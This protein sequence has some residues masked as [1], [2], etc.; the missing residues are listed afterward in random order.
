MSDSFRQA[1]GRKVISRATA[2]ELGEVNHLLLDARR[3]QIGAV[4]IGKGKKAQLVEWAQVT[5]FGPDAVMV[6][7]EGALRAPAD[8]RERDAAEGKLDL[9][10]KRALT[11][12]GTELGTID[13][14]TFDADTGTVEMLRIS[15]KEVPGGSVLGN[16]TYAVIIDATQV[17]AP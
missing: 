4:I 11:E 5:G 13:D 12:T 2:E 15:D 1:A 10:G 3:Q 7:D 14:V 9:V 8:D 16:G 17:P 6:S